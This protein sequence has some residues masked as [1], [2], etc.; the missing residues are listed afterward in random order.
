MIHK[1]VHDPTELKGSETKTESTE[2][3][4]ADNKIDQDQDIS[5]SSDEVEEKEKEELK[6]RVLSFILYRENV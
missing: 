1:S 5:K 4:L 2:E 3:T 6:V